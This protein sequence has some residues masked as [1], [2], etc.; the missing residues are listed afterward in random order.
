LDLGCRLYHP[1][2]KYGKKR[3]V[4]LES[5]LY[6]YQKALSDLSNSDVKCHK[7]QPEEMVYDGRAWSSEILDHELL[8]GSQIWDSYN[9]FISNLYK[10][11]IKKGLKQKDI[12]RMTVNELVNK[13]RKWVKVTLHTST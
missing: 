5:K 1:E 8:P 12:D 6:Y 10:T 4:I 13:I 3:S 9:Y 2:D 11:L 7:G